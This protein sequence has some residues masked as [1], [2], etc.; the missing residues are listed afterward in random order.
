MVLFGG[1]G[2][3]QF[4]SASSSELAFLIRGGNG[5]IETTFFDSDNFF[6]KTIDSNSFEKN[7]TLIILLNFS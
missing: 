3:R 2:M 7:S 4:L 6:F 5:S 1:I